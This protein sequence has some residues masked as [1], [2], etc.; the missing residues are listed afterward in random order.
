M[1]ILTAEQHR[2]LAKN[3]LANAGKPGFPS[4]E[5]GA[6]MAENHE[7]VA[8]MIEYSAKHGPFLVRTPPIAPT[9]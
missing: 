5:R 2:C 1:T 3:I 4:K 9:S 7:T 6:Q 8:K